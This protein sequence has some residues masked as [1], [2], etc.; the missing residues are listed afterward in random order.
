MEDCHDVVS[1]WAGLGDFLISRDRPGDLLLSGSS[2]IAL[3]HHVPFFVLSVVS[4]WPLSALVADF[5]LRSCISF[6]LGPSLLNAF[7]SLCLEQIYFLIQFEGPPQC[8]TK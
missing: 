4:T 8:L 2:G 1:R 7:S 5:D 3:R 6:I